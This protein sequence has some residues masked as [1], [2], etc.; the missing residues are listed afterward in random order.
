M[1]ECPQ[2]AIAR[3]EQKVAELEAAQMWRPIVNAPKDGGK[4]LLMNAYDGRVAKGYWLSNA[5]DGIGA[6]VW[7]YV[8]TEPSDWMPLPP[9]RRSKSH[10]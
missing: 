7:P 1:S 6:W 2:V 5:V 10:E 9:H 4:I 8:Q 3:L